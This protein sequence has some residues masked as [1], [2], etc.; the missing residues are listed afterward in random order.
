MSFPT[1]RHGGLAIAADTAPC[2]C[3]EQ[4]HLRS[5]GCKNCSAAAPHALR[6]CAAERCDTAIRG[7]PNESEA[8]AFWDAGVPWHWGTMQRAAATA[9]EVCR[10]WSVP[11][12][13]SAILHEFHRIASNL[14]S[15]LSCRHHH[16]RHFRHCRFRHPGMSPTLR[17]AVRGLPSTATAVSVYPTIP[18]MVW[19][20][21]NRCHD[22]PLPMPIPATSHDTM[23]MCVKFPLRRCR[24]RHYRCRSHLHCRRRQ[25][26]HRHRRL[27]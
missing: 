15:Q 13:P 14:R 5:A 27:P 11:N 2:W 19:V 16:F 18:K 8:P 24:C 21:N 26:H 9:K 3:V 7:K 17:L 10:N 12:E 25:R 4:D 6:P 1:Q 22:V 20:V 23:M